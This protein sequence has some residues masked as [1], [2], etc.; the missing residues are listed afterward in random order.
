[1]KRFITRTLYNANSGG[2]STASIVCP[3]RKASIVG[4]SLSAMLDPTQSD[5][6]GVEISLN[7][8]PYIL[9]SGVDGVLAQLFVKIEFLTSGISPTAENIHVATPKIPIF[10]NQQI[11]SHLTVLFGIFATRAIIWFEY[12]G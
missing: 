3:W 1:M 12:E 8:A 5:E 7:P 2:A 11:F 4:V 9:Q 10:Q 6:A